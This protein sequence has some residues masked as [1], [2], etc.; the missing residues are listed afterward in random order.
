MAEPFLAEIRLFSFKFA[1][2]GWAQ[3]NGQLLPIAQNMALF[4]LIGTTY[5]GDGKTTFALPNLQGRVPVN[6]NQ[7]S[8]TYG[9]VGGEEAHTLT[10]NEMPMH[11]HQTSASNDTA[12]PLA[13]D[14]TGKVWG[15]SF[16][17]NIYSPTTNTAMSPNA[18]GTSGGS[19]PH[20]NMQPYTVVNYCIALSGIFP[21][22]N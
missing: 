7:G 8:I 1:P 5:G 19:K 2:R 20:N 3:C 13:T 18:I 15:V 22:R 6:P 4:S 9:A 10:V 12:A 16:N 11:T 17:N 14:P 21:P